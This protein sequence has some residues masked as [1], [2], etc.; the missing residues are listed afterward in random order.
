[1]AVSCTVCCISSWVGL[2][3]TVWVS[4]HGVTERSVLEYLL[5]RTLESLVVTVEVQALT[6]AKVST[7]VAVVEK[8][9]PEDNTVL[10]MHCCLAGACLLMLGLVG[11]PRLKVSGLLACRAM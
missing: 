1:V 3:W 5:W 6:V 4:D 7:Q 9:V 11:L 10:L 8:K 2:Q